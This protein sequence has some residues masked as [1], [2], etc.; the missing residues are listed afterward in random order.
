M[1]ITSPTKT[2]NYPDRFEDCQTAIE[3]VFVQLV[4]EATRAGWHH[5]EVLAAL[6][7][8]VDITALALDTRG[9]TDV[10]MRLSKLRQTK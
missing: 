8:L 4:V 6:A 3:E 10:E 1:N 2:G 9:K 5:E 7:S